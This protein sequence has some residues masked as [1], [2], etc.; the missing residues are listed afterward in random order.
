MLSEQQLIEAFVR[1]L[2]QKGWS[3]LKIVGWPDKQPGTSGEIDA[4]IEG[5]SQKI[6]L[7]HT[8]IDS[9]PSQRADNARFRVVL[10]RLESDF[11]G[12]ITSHIE[13]ARQ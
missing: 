4:L 11:K 13:P 2:R 10:E 5:S 1:Q 8:S 9:Y 3:D 12:Q 7:E 6:A